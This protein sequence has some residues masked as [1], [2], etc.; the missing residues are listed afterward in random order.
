MYIFNFLVW[1]IFAVAKHP[2]IQVCKAFKKDFDTLLL[3]EHSVHCTMYFSAACDAIIK[4]I[5]CRVIR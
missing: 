3:Y 1:S 5:F 2:H 4:Y